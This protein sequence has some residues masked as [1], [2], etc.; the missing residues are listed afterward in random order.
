MAKLLAPV[1]PPQRVIHIV[2]RRR[3]EDDVATFRAA[4]VEAGELIVDVDEDQ[5]SRDRQ[6]FCSG[7]AV[8]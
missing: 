7:H 3:A 5:R 2:G 1:G 4:G 6:V 8:I